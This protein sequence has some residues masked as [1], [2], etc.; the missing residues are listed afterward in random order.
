MW[1]TLNPNEA[2]PM[3]VTK[4]PVDAQLRAIV[5]VSYPDRIQCQQPGCGHSVYRR[6]HIVHDSGITILLGSTC[7][8]KRY[9]GAGALGQPNHGGSGDGL[10]LTAE[11]RQILVDNTDALLAHYDQQRDERPNNA[12]TRLSSYQDTLQQLRVQR[13][14]RHFPPAEP[15]PWSW[16][17]KLSSML[18]FHMQDGSGWVRAQHHD[19]KQMLVPWPVFEGWDESLPAFIGSSHPTIEGFSIS[20]LATT[21]GYLRVHSTWEKMSGNWAEISREIV[22]RSAT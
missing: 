11:Q 9:G 2:P 4:Q 12:K 7:F 6:V 5:S 22:K 3:N 15:T 13:L 8:A 18:Y 10:E 21:V 20:D 17:K 16:V 14:Q 19:G 1:C